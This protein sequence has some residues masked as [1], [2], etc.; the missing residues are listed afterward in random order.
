MLWKLNLW[1]F[2]LLITLTFFLWRS[3]F[4]NFFLPIK[5]SLHSPQLM[6]HSLISLHNII[7]HKL[8]IL[9]I[10]L[11]ELNFLNSSLINMISISAILLDLL[12]WFL[13]CSHIH[14]RRFCKFK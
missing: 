10:G 12:L 3:C 2:C 8:M 11:E 6:H 14:A 7:K 5:C 13:Q 4:L 1:L 9:W